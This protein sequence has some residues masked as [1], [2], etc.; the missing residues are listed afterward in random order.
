MEDTFHEKGVELNQGRTS[1]MY[2]ALQWEMMQDR[3]HP[4][5]YRTLAFPLDSKHHN[6]RPAWTAFGTRP[7]DEREVLAHVGWSR[8][9]IGRSQVHEFSGTA[10]LVASRQTSK[11]DNDCLWW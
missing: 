1:W 5:F 4:F 6:I 3:F 9:R 7:S 2:H 8:D 11:A 10:E